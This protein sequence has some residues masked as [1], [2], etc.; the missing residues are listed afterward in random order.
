MEEIAELL[1]KT[2][3]DS[4]IEL[5]EVSKDLEIDVLALKNIEE[6]HIGA[7]KDIFMVKNYIS[8]YAKY[9]GLSSDKINDEFSEYLFEYTSKIPVEQIEKTIKQNIKE[10][11]EEKV[12]SPY[13]LDKPKSKKSMYVLIYISLLILVILAIFWS[14]NQNF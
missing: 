9:L 1:R 7:F 8:E 6:G 10:D 5:E 12:I 4:G 14:I 13:T 11:D 2:R 3:E